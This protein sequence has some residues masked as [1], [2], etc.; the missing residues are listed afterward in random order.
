MGG[1]PQKAAPTQAS[2][3]AWRCLCAGRPDNIR[4]FLQ[5][6][7][8]W[9][10]DD[11]FYSLFQGGHICFGEAFGFDGVV[12]VDGDGCGTEDPVAGA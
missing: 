3:I 9:F 10:G 4:G 8:Y 1:G 6:S 12:D 7:F 11:L 2:L 5:G